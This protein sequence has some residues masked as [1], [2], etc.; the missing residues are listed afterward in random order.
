MHFYLGNCYEKQQNLHANDFDH[1]KFFVRLHLRYFLED[2]LPLHL[3]FVEHLHFLR[4]TRFTVW[5]QTKNKDK[6]ILAWA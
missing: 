5:S 3:V 4:L 1:E 2:I 6:S